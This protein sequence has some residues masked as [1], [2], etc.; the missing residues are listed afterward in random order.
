[1]VV[2]ANNA[3][4]FHPQKY[5]C[6]MAIKTT[7]EEDRAMKAK[8]AEV[9][10]FKIYSVFGS[11]CIDVCKAAYSSLAS[12]RIGLAHGLIDQSALTQMEPNLWTS[13]LTNNIDR[14]N[15]YISVFGGEKIKGRRN[16]V[17]IVH[18][19]DEDLPDL[20]NQ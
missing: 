4:G 17:I 7:P 5:D 11:S 19:L 3:N 14:V 10:G 1:M 15:L 12:S 9:A 8:A 20:E 16:Q 2:D 6:Y 13:F 18:P